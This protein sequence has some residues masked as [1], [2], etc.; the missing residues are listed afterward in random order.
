MKKI[1]LVFLLILFGLLEAKNYSES[2]DVVFRSTAHEATYSF[3]IDISR[4]QTIDWN[5]LDTNINFIICKATE[6][7][8][9]TDP[10]FSTFWSNINPRVKK[11]AYHFFRPQNSGIEQAKLFL[12]TANLEAGHLLPV[13]DVEHGRIYKHIHPSVAAKHLKEMIR[14]I[15][16]ELQVK[17]IIYTNAG[18]WNRQFA[19]FFKS[20]EGEYHLWIADYRFREEPAIPKGWQDWT[21]WQHSCKGVVKGVLNEVD[22]NVCKVDLN[23]LTIK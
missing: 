14:Y 17:P 10:K 7:I 8:T 19:P 15:E 3:G 11:G 16:E 12:S 9:I 18:F 5:K 22:L 4:Y 2:T 13:L 20:M 23:D 21:I 6:G 1:P